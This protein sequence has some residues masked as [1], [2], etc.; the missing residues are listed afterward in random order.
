[1]QQ[2]WT[3]AQHDGPNHPGLCAPLRSGC[4][5]V[6][7]ELVTGQLLTP[8]LGLPGAA[9]FAIKLNN[10]PSTSSASS[11]LR[12]LAVALPV[13]ARGS[14]RAV[15]PFGSRLVPSPG[16]RVFQPPLVL[17]VEAS[18][19]VAADVTST[20]NALH[21]QD[22]EFLPGL[23]AQPLLEGERHVAP[24]HRRISLQLCGVKV[25]AP[26]RLFAVLGPGGVT[27]CNSSALIHPAR[28][29][30]GAAPAAASLPDATPWRVTISGLPASAT[31][32]GLLESGLAQ[33]SARLL[34]LCCTPRS[35]FSRRF[36]RGDEGVLAK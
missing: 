25:A 17:E 3:I 1:M 8:S 15:K 4:L 19:S 29:V 16:S 10:L 30:S 14:V 7:P 9:R 6:P 2:T 23:I 5:P 32:T 20:L 31:T 12:A 21:R 11:L 24:P 18:A 13:R 22:V 28:V 26:G 27:V 33:P 36:N 35:P 34:S